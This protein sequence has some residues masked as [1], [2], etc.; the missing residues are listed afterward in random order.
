M[1]R[2]KALRWSVLNDVKVSVA[3][4]L[5]E[6][7]IVPENRPGPKRKL[8]QYSN[9]PFSGAMLVLGS[10]FFTDFFNKAIQ[11]G[12]QNPASQQMF[13]FFHGLPW[14]KVNS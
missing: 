7:N 12:I 4:T 5:S 3:T 1:F 8:V 13:A 9:H 2:N 14:M 11:L 10:V 6:T